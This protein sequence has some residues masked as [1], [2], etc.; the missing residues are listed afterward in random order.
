MTNDDDADR[1]D[2]PPLSRR[3]RTAPAEDDASP[4]GAMAR[5][6]GDH[7][8]E[9]SIAAIRRAGRQPES[10]VTFLDLEIWHRALRM[11]DDS[12]EER[13]RGQIHALLS[14]PPKEVV[15]RLLA[16]VSQVRLDLGTVAERAAADVAQIRRE[17]ATVGDLV[18]AEKILGNLGEMRDKVND[19]D[20]GS[21][22]IR[23]LAW[24]ALGGAFGA[25]VMFAHLTYSRGGMDTG[26][27][28]RLQML[29]RKIERVDQ[30]LDRD[31]FRL[32]VPAPS[33]P[34]GP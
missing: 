25:L 27:E 8:S 16:G 5:M 29:E 28:L 6:S 23:R 4:W 15:D 13:W 3:P 10:V 22:F 33:G 34:S 14:R 24:A 18:N 32:G 30:Q 21:K 17:L 20:R 9:R 1:E 26:I 19:H 31:R 11:R 2:T 7:P 12:R